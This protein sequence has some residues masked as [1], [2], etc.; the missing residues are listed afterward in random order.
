MTIETR[1][2]SATDK[3][4]VRAISLS[5]WEHD[6]VPDIFLQW[7]EDP[8]WYPIGVFE[9]NQLVSYLAI[10]QVIDTS[11]AW[12]K[13][14]R[15]SK[16][17]HGKGYAFKAIKHSITMSKELGINELRYSTSS[18]NQ[19]SMNLAIKAGFEL[20]DTVGYV[21]IHKPYPAHPKS[22]SNFI[23][24]IV[25]AIRVQEVIS[26]N[27][28]LI[29]TSTIPSTW[30]FYNKDLNGLKKINEK[31]QLLLVIDEVGITQGL[32]FARKLGEDGISIG[33]YSIYCQ[34][35]ATFVD[36]MSRILEEL[37]SDETDRSVFFLGPNATEWIKDMAIL[38][39]DWEDRNFLLYKM[40][41]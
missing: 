19:A 5:V 8:L 36:I 11:Y 12:V 28:N 14:L 17:H 38:P 1:A 10:Q 31:S 2:L 26:Q 34:E 37:E 7:L 29:E 13:A 25:D 41:L 27:P 4:A 23:P 21:R 39:E 16:E 22:S 20:I 3:D 40:Q 6:Y 15:T 18:R 30:E 33:A 32:Y 9:D 24:L 35:R